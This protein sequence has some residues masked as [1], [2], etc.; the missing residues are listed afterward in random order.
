MFCSKCGK[1][2]PDDSQFCSG[3]GYKIGSQVIVNEPSNIIAQPQILTKQ[4]HGFVTFWIILWLAINIISI[5]IFIV[6]YRNSLFGGTFEIII[7]FMIDI[8]VIAGYFF[9][10]KWKKNGFWMVVMPRFLFIPLLR[11]FFDIQEGFI[12]IIILII[13]SIISYCIL[14]IQKNGKSTW[15]QLEKGW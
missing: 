7:L 10:L 14:R 11:N 9:L 2:L 1:Q 3:C 15:D 8:T 4:R 12:F 13:W 5:I 6:E